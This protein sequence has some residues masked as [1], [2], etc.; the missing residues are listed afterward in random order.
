MKLLGAA[1][2]RIL[3]TTRRDPLAALV[4]APPSRQI[5]FLH[6]FLFLLAQKAILNDR[7]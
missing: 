4:L 3:A 2:A 1:H 6:T 7:S 5:V